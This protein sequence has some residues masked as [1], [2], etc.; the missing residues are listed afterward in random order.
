MTLAGNLSSVGGQAHSRVQLLSHLMSPGARPDRVDIIISCL[1]WFQ[2]KMQTKWHRVSQGTLLKKLEAGD[3]R[4]VALVQTCLPVSYRVLNWGRCSLY[5]WYSQ[6]LSTS[7]HRAF[8]NIRAQ[9][10]MSHTF[11]L[12]A[13]DTQMPTPPHNCWGTL[14][15]VYVDNTRLDNRTSKS[16]DTADSN[17]KCKARMFIQYWQTN[18]NDEFQFCLQGHQIKM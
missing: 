10:C 16:I 11:S 9:R 17:E 7:V 8:K 3:W 4:E 6:F 14:L 18:L 1:D 12:C 2:L 5:T 13:L 15:F